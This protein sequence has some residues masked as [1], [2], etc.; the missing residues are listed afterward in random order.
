MTS[1]RTRRETTLIALAV[2]GRRGRVRVPDGAHV[3]NGVSSLWRRRHAP[4]VERRGIYPRDGRYRA[5]WRRPWV[6]HGTRTDSRTAA[7]FLAVSS[8][9]GLTKSGDQTKGRWSTVGRNP[10]RGQDRAAVRREVRVQVGVPRAPSPAGAVG[11]QRAERC[12]SARGHSRA[13]R[14]P[15]G[16][17]TPSPRETPSGPR[18]RPSRRRPRGRARVVSGAG[19]SCREPQAQPVAGVCPEG[20][21]WKATTRVDAAASTT[22]PALRRRAAATPSAAR[23]PPRPSAPRLLGRIRARRRGRRGRPGCWAYHFPSN[24]I[25]RSGK[26]RDLRGD[27][28]S[29]LSLVEVGLED[30]RSSRAG[31][32]SGRDHPANVLDQRIGPSV[33]TSRRILAIDKAV[34][35]L[36]HAPPLPANRRRERQGFVRRNLP[37]PL[38]YTLSFQE[39]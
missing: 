9:G 35:P 10:R 7:R 24:S 23:R 37:A 11:D 2:A 16:W 8:A 17:R 5:R 39:A 28:A 3:G 38:S 18:T 1:S 25:F 13:F 22:A 34:R 19:A 29:A 4:G 20:A 31:G 14:R 6:R 12:P 27:G 32:R 15:T 33:T 30:T 26:L 21:S 36:I